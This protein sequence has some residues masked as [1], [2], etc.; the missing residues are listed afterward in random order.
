[1]KRS[2]VIPRAERTQRRACWW[3]RKVAAEQVTSVGAKLATEQENVIERNHGVGKEGCEATTFFR[4]ES[5]FS[6]HVLGVS[7]YSAVSRSEVRRDSTA[8]RTEQLLH[9]H[10]HVVTQRKLKGERDQ[11]GQTKHVYGKQHARTS[12]CLHLLENSSRRGGT[13]SG[14]SFSQG[15]PGMILEIFRFLLAVDQLCLP[16]L[17]THGLFS[18]RRRSEVTE[19]MFSLFS[20]LVFIESSLMV[21]RSR[22]LGMVLVNPGSGYSCSATSTAPALQTSGQ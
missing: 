18:T 21:S 3:S 12:W 17:S 2:S 9:V 1:L 19:E 22:L 20:S 10:S 7:K 15:A 16:A 5:L 8:L 6:L 11:T 13:P 14:C 4:I